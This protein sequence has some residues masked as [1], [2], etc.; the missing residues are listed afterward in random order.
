M[1]EKLKNKAKNVHGNV[2]QKDFSICQN[3]I[4]FD[5]CASLEK[6]TAVTKADNRP[7]NSKYSKKYFIIDQANHE[8]DY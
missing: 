5:E 6:T 1:L 4:N 8:E 3:F 2:F 7:G